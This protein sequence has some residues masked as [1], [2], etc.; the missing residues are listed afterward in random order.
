MDDVTTGAPDEQSV[1]EFYVKS[2]LHLAKASFNLR[3][4]STNSL[5]LSD[6]RQSHDPEPLPPDLTTGG[7]ERLVLG[8]RC[9]IDRDELAFQ[10][11]IQ[12]SMDGGSILKNARKAH[13][14]ILKPRPLL[15]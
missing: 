10:G 11:R 8:V 13:A 12:D 4:F 14:K 1:N 9:N 2:K 7:S 5:E 15:R 6:A 3:K